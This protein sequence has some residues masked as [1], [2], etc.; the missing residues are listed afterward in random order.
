MRRAQARRL[1]SDQC[2]RDQRRIQPLSTR[3]RSTG[4][5]RLDE[6]GV[7]AG[8]AL[9]STFRFMG[10]DGSIAGTIKAIWR[11]VLKRN[12]S[13]Q[14][15]R[16]RSRRPLPAAGARA[17]AVVRDRRLRSPIGG[18]IPAHHGPRPRSTPGSRADDNR[19]SLPTDGSQR[20]IAASHR[21]PPHGQ[22]GGLLSGLLHQWLP[23]SPATGCLWLRE[24]SVASH[25]VVRDHAAVPQR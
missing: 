21:W 8:P 5:R 1:P 16:L 20:S 19:R 2:R 22:P 13:T 9:N 24:S 14:M 6:S 12:K 18:P 25:R 11:Q 23:A 10:G 15:Q 4:S 17:A 3:R 7:T